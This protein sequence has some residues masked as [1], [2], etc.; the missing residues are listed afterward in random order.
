MK[1]TVFITLLFL[2]FGAFAQNQGEAEP[3]MYHQF[4]YMKV[5]PGMNAD[6]LEV[7]KAWKKIHEAKVKAGKQHSWALLRVVSPWGSSSE[8]DYVTRTSF[9]GEQQLAAAYESNIMPEN[10][11]SLLSKEEIA[12]VQ[13]TGVTRTLVKSEVY[14]GVRA[15]WNDDPIKVSVFN[16]FDFPEGKGRSDHLRVEREIWAPIHQSRIDAGEM[17]GWVLLRMVMPYG[18]AM[19]YHDATVDLYESMEEYLTQNPAPHARKVHAGK[20]LNNMLDRTG[21][22]ATLVRGEIRQVVDGVPPLEN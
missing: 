18:A 17:S 15:I 7:E 22:N 10:W 5:A 8:Y 6:Y 4:D 14:A 2:G 16:Y 20:D 3:T 13:K 1:P 11:Q 21:E 19:P 12:T 9:E